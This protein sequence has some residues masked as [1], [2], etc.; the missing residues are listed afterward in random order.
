[1]TNQHHANFEHDNC[2]HVNDN[3]SQWNHEDTSQWNYQWQNATIMTQ[4]HR[5]NTSPWHH[6]IFYD[7]FSW[8]VWPR[9]HVINNNMSPRQRGILTKRNQVITS[10]WQHVAMTTRK[11]DNCHVGNCGHDNTS[12]TTTYVLCFYD[13]TASWHNVTYKLTRRF[14]NTSAW[15]ITIMKIVTM[16]TRYHEDTSQW[17]YH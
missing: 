1:M 4:R 2:D 8:Q 13:S 10:L 16:S 12:P 7:K 14:E 6:V 11:H 17:H 5:D 3:T 15:Q 9:H